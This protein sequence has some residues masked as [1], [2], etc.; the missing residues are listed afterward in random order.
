[1]PSPDACPLCGGAQDVPEFAKSGWRFV[2]CRGCGLVSLRPLPT[3]AAVAAHHDASYRDGRYAA[4]AAADAVRAA[5]ARRRLELVRPD[6]TDGPWLDV[7]CSTGA[8]VAEAAS[9]GLDAEGIELSAAAVAT[10]R[11]R[12]LAVG[13]G[14][15]ETFV[16]RR[17]YAVVTAF[18]VVEHA[19][20]PLAF[21][22]RVAG[23]LLPHGLLA[24]TLPDAASPTAR[25]LGRRWFYYAPPDHVHYFTPETARRLVRAGGLDVTRVAPF[26]KPMT[27]DYAAAQLANLAPFLAP[28]VRGLAAVLPRGLRAR[29]WRLPLGEMLVIAR[30]PSS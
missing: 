29:G 2:R 25:L 30:W 21:V 23:W 16:P 15:V 28:P 1:M 20:D 11:A 19:L 13:Q 18:D 24:L 10:A 27:L 7:G 6:A 12:G 26:R 8:F 4:F 9:A 22:R 5:I 17:R 14:A 3:P